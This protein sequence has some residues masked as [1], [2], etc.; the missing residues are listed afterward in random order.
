MRNNK[1][2]L[3]DINLNL[4]VRAIPQSAT[5]AI[6]EKSDT[7]RK[8]GRTIF[9]LG[10]GQSPFPVPAPVVEELK[11]NAYHK[12]YLPVKGLP[13]LR[14]AVAE[15]H[16]RVNG[17]SHNAEDVLLGISDCSLIINFKRHS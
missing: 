8:E 1:K 14:E 7:L 13:Q 4:N 10:L 3:P 16:C 15:Y 2:F 9:K 6:N 5:L 12:E 17:T 11:V